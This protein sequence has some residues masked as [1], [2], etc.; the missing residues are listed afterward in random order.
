MPS[1][2]FMNYSLQPRLILFS[3]IHLN[4]FHNSTTG[5]GTVYFV[6]YNYNYEYTF[7][8]HLSAV[9]FISSFQNFWILLRSLIIEIYELCLHLKEPNCQSDSLYFLPN[10][11]SEFNL[12]KSSIAFANVKVMYFGHPN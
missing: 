3:N 5:C 7:S 6:Y 9:L 8:E 1:F 10:N 12:T 2:L 4:F 11:E